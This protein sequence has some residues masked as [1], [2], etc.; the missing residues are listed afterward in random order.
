MNN[1]EHSPHLFAS[2]SLHIGSQRVI[3]KRS[4]IGS[5]KYRKFFHLSYLNALTPYIS[6]MKRLPGIGIFITA[7]CAI[8][9]SMGGF[10]SSFVRRRE[11]V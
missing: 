5:G 6:E 7:L 8:L 10:L 3:R 11:L 4:R 2:K 9:E 1:H